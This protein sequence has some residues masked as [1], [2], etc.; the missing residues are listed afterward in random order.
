MTAVLGLAGHDAERRGVDEKIAADYLDP[1]AA[2]L[3]GELPERLIVERRISRSLQDQIARHPAADD[4]G[5]GEHMRI[6]HLVRLPGLQC[7][8]GRGELRQRSRSESLC[9]IE[10]LDD[11]VVVIQIYGRGRHER[12]A[13]LQRLQRVPLGVRRSCD[14]SGGG[15]EQ[16]QDPGAGKK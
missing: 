2:H 12:A 9:G 8:R 13:L 11:T 4:G 14:E 6:E 16:R 1:R 7:E 10:L 15:K 5:V 3:R